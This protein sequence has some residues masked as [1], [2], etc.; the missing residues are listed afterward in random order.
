M[1]IKL[2]PQQLRVLRMLAERGGQV[3]TRE[4]I[5]RELWGNE[6]YVGFDRGLN[7][8]IA[9]IRAA[10]NDDPEAARF[11]QTV[12]RQGYRFVAPVERGPVVVEAPRR[13]R[14]WPAAL[15]AFA[16]MAIGGWAVLSPAR[17]TR[18]AVLPIENLTGDTA[19]A[20]VA[21]G[22][23]DELT[24]QLGAANPGKLAVIGRT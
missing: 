20:P 9:G 21:L 11:I 2:S 15:V 22:L 5:Q 6:T 18:L 4:E 3:C 8:C 13:R 1:L 12:P 23:T 16:A 17:T 7:V 14:L 10:L 19:D 24:T